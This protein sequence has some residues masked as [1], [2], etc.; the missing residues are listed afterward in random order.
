MMPFTIDQI[1]FTID[2]I[3]AVHTAAL[4]AKDSG[5]PKEF[6]KEFN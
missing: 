4:C 2:Q 6:Y 5:R 3:T 1:D